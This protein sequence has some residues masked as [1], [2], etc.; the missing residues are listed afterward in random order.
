MPL[1][2]TVNT[3]TSFP[4]QTPGQ[5]RQIQTTSCY[6]T[7]F[8]TAFSPTFSQLFFIFSFFLFLSVFIHYFR[9]ATIRPCR[10]TVHVTSQRGRGKSPNLKFLRQQNDNISAFV[11]IRRHFKLFQWDEVNVLKVH[12][13]YMFRTFRKLA[14]PD[15]FFCLVGV[16]AYG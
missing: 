13:T 4:S 3:F 5:Q 1:S 2:H 9:H 14:K 12:I 8:K 16:S 10:A 11:Q 7:Y 6:S 15:F